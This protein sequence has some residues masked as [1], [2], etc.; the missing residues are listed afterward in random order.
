[1]AAFVLIPRR[2]GSSA[3]GA[4]CAGPSGLIDK[5]MGLLRFNTQSKDVHGTSLQSSVLFS[6]GVEA[7]VFVG[8]GVTSPMLCDQCLNRIVICGM[9]H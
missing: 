1:M 8:S 3:F 5:C 9:S 2:A 7:E 6:M 4:R